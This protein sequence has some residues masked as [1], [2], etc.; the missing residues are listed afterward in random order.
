MQLA[1]ITHSLM[2]DFSSTVT[3]ASRRQ[4]EAAMVVLGAMVEGVVVLSGWAKGEGEEVSEA[5][6]RVAR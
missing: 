1:P 2:T 4:L 3:L 5:A 6:G